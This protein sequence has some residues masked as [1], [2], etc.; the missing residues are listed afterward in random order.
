MRNRRL[1]NLSALAL[2]GSILVRASA[3]DDSIGVLATAQPITVPLE[4]GTAL[5]TEFVWMPKGEHEISAFAADG[6]A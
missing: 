4:A 1:P 2:A 6:T 5:P 3:S